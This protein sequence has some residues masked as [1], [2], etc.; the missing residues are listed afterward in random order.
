M[1]ALPHLVQTQ[2]PKA[3]SGQPPRAR[4]S[5]KMREEALGMPKGSLPRARTQGRGPKPA[6]TSTQLPVS[7]P[8]L[9]YQ[10]LAPSQQGG[11]CSTR[12]FLLAVVAEIRLGDRRGSQRSRQPPS[13]RSRTTTRAGQQQGER[14]PSGTPR[15][16]SF[17][18][19]GHKTMKADGSLWREQGAGPERSPSG[20]NW[21]QFL[22]GTFQEGSAF[23]LCPFSPSPLT[24]VSPRHD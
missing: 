22:F 4:L 17:Q 7:P 24:R 15:R 2:H 6:G 10:Q 1:A 5:H 20:R 23:Q 9:L 11:I 3:A 14:L 13:A 19:H 16:A 18:Q 12:A 21:R 8:A